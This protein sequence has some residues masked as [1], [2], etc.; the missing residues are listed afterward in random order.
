MLVRFED[1]GKNTDTATLDFGSK[2]KKKV[3]ELDTKV[4][5]GHSEPQGHTEARN[6]GFSQTQKEPEIPRVSTPR[7]DK[8]NFLTRI[9]KVKNF[10]IYLAIGLILVMVAIYMTTFNTGN[11]TPRQPRTPEQNFAR[12]IE[13]RLISA[14]SQ[15]HGAGRVQAMV[16]VVGSATIEVAYNVDE[17]TVTQSGGAGNATTTTT[18]V[19]TPVIIHGRDGPQPLILFEIKPQIKG[20]I[21]VA[22]GAQDVGVRLQLLRAV[23]A[24]IADDSVRIEIFTGR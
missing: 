7:N 21:I 23:Q 18:V 11:Q 20:V 17:R 24:V 22:S 9:K 3:A 4:D 14:L 2:E 15:I 16:T 6:L 8:S 5:V 19:R 13:G 10:E 1:K 12:E